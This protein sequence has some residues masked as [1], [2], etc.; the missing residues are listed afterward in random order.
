MKPVIHVLTTEHRKDRHKSIVAQS[1][2]QGFDIKWFK[3]ER[4]EEIKDVKKC[5]C[6]GHKRIIQY[7][8]DNKMPF[9]RIAEDDCIFL[10]EGALQYYLDNEPKYYDAY[11]G[12]IYQGE[13]IDKRIMNGMSG[14][15]T[16][17]SV[18]SHFYNFILNEVP[19][20]CHLD[21]FLGDTAF[22]HQYL[23]PPKYVCT[24]SGGFSDNLRREMYY[25]AYLVGK[26]IYGQ[27]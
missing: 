22:K 3:G 7:A 20:D 19:D 8:K 18:Q 23:L 27:D 24:Q 4:G 21:R 10:G 26:P 9:I 5:I 6:Q 12:V 13:V 15:L 17:F 1:E 16:F 25:H 11:F 2:A 14:V